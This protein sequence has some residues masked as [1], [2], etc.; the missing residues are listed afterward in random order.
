[1]RILR[2]FA[3]MTL[4]ASAVG[5]K[6][7]K[8]DGESAGTRLAVSA[9][10]QKPIDQ[11]LAGQKIGQILVGRISWLHGEQFQKGPLDRAPDLYLFYYTVSW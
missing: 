2:L 8:H 11:V 4:C 7:D 3:I 9:E 6:N 10:E 5:C 1:M